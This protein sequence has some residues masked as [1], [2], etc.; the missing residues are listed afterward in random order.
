MDLKVVWPIYR[1]NAGQQQQLQQQQRQNHVSDNFQQ[2]Q[3]QQQHRDYMPFK[4]P[5]MMEKAEEIIDQALAAEKIG[6]AGILRIHRG[7]LYRPRGGVLFLQRN[8]NLNFKGKVKRLN[9]VGA[10]VI[11]H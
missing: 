8:A 3:Q 5:L 7:S 10:S 1:L 2:Q 11:S 6:Q 4:P 9:S